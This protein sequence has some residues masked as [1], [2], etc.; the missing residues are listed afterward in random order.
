MPLTDV[1][2]PFEFISKYL[3]VSTLPTHLYLAATF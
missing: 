2:T 3:L 1:H